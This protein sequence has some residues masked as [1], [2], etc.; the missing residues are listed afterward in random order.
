MEMGMFAD[1]LKPAM[2]RDNASPDD[3]LTEDGLRIC[4]VCGQKTL[5]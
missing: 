1:I 4:A 2:S 3:L 5:V